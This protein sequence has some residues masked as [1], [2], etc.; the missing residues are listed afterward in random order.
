MPILKEGHRI[1]WYNKI[2]KGG[3]NEII[4]I[5]RKATKFNKL[6]AI[7]SC[8]LFTGAASGRGRVEGCLGRSQY[9]L[10]SNITRTKSG[11]TSVDLFV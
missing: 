8:A 6:Y 5:E 7:Q 9:I 10:A 2:G 4:Q 11:F 3:K 1:S